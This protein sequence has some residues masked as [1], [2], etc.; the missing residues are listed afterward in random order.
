L[1][2]Y[3]SVGLSTCDRDRFLAALDADA[4]QNRALRKAAERFKVASRSPA[5]SMVA[6]HDLSS[7]QKV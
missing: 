6:R 1:Q 4:R 3:E 7:D 5:G 2:Q